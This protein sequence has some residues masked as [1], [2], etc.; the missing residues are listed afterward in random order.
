MNPVECSHIPLVTGT[1]EGNKNFSTDSFRQPKTGWGEGRMGRA[2]ERDT[3]PRAQSVAS[4]QEG[5]KE[6]TSPAA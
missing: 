2:R 6:L 1:T 5:G 3:D 4:T